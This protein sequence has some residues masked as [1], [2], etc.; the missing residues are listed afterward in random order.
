MIERTF[1]RLQK[2]P[3]VEPGF[4]GAG[5][6]AV[7]VLSS[8][9]LVKSDP[10]VLL[11]DD[12]MNVP[13]R[14]AMGGAHPHAGLETVTLILEGTLEDRDEGA[15]GAGDVVWMTAGRG[16]IHNEH[17]EMEGRSRILQ[18]WIRLSRAE[19][20]APPRFEIVRGATAPVRRE[21]VRSRG[22]TAAPRER[23]AHPRSTTCR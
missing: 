6:T 3:P 16:I 20:A 2:T 23:C 22:C 17:I 4:M 13:Q 11:M 18:L 19:R 10:F 14:R 15:L 21:H 8:D 7:E 9:A 12:R 1:E 5:H